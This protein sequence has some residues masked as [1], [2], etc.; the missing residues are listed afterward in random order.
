MKHLIVI[1]FFSVFVKSFS[2]NTPPVATTSSGKAFSD[3]T[4]NITLK[5]VDQD[6][7]N[8]TYTLITSPSN[9]T[10][11]ITDGVLIYT[12][13][14]GFTGSDTIT[15]KVNDGLSDSN[16]AQL[17]INVIEKEPNLNWATYY[18]T[19][20][21][22]GSVQDDSGNTFAI[23]RFWDFSNFRD[24]TSLG[25]IYP[26]VEKDGY[27]AKYNNLGD[28]QWVSTFGGE[29]ND[30]ATDIAI[31][32]DGNLVVVGTI[33]GVATFSDGEQIDS[34]SNNTDVTVV[35][36]LNHISGDIIWKTT[37]GDFGVPTVNFRSDNSMIITSYRSGTLRFNNLNYVDGS[38]IIL[39]NTV[40]GLSEFRDIV[41]DLSLIHI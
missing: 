25:A 2:Q 36:K 41:F 29:F 31:G 28:L 17:Q 5:A 11:S 19:S 8:L 30:L 35:I 6:G 37:T 38:F 3:V 18:S 14:S 13:N 20:Q 34:G 4:T 1:I 26:E 22:T 9:G 16:E 39:I 40:S 33:R 21:L 24:N 10:A 23:G 12:S 27:V 32:N 15:Y 7:D